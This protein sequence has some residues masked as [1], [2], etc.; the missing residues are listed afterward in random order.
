MSTNSIHPKKNLAVLIHLACLIL[1]I[2][3]ISILYVNSNFG[4]GIAWIR[5]ESYIESDLFYNQLQ[6]DIRAIFDYG[7]LR[8]A[9]ET[10]GEPDMDKEVLRVNYGPNSTISYNMSDIIKMGGILRLS[11]PR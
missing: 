6:S 11:F 7:T 10:E 1:V 3:S 2:A 8:D 5:S 4:R 9:F